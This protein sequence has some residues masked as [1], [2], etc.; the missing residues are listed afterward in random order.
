MPKR[1]VRR[2]TSSEA[3]RKR[4]ERA[5]ET[6]DQG[7]S[8][9]RT[10]RQRQANSH[11]DIQRRSRNAESERNRRLRQTAEQVEI[12]RTAD[13][14]RTALHRTTEA[15][16]QVETRRR[17]NRRRQ[18]N[19]RAVQTAAQR[20]TTRQVNAQQQRSSRST[21]RQQPSFLALS[22]DP[23]NTHSS[24]NVGEMSMQC[25]F[26]RAKKW[27]GERP[28][29][30]CQN[31]K[32]NLPA[33]LPPPEPLYSLLTAQDSD[34]LHFRSNIRTYNCCFQ[35][36][37]FGSTIV[38]EQGFMPTFKIQGQIYHSIGPP[39]ERRGEQP[40]FLQIYFMQNSDDQ[41][42]RRMEITS[43]FSVSPRE[44][45]VRQLQQM[46]HEVN[47]YVLDFKT[48]LE[49]HPKTCMNSNWSFMPKKYRQASMNVDTTLPLA[50]KLLP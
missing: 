7:E 2:F 8:R 47:P 44:H 33:L 9:R 35:M 30:C 31:G 41:A 39:T 21:I 38:A 46:L 3:K 19:A 24:D 17:S 37:S 40:K 27:Q 10:E 25:S 11:A 13:R 26:C 45:T 43:N 50:P 15:V 49:Q 14:E 4:S 18:A 36:T 6:S 23:T 28:T 20:Q 16:Q 12:R 48:Q 1:K 34:S 32:V 5:E 22:Y 29:L 42:R